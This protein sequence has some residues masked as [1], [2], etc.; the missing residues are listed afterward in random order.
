[1]D[2]KELPQLDSEHLPENPIA[3]IIFS[4]EKLDAFL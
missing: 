3:N 1:M 2:V 4:G